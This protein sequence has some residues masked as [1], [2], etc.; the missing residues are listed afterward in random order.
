MGKCFFSKVEA[1]VETLSKR[2][3]ICVST[4]EIG[5]YWITSQAQL[6]YRDS[7]A[8]SRRE[9]MLCL[10]EIVK[11]NRQGLIPF[12]TLTQNE[13]V[14]ISENPRVVLR[15]IDSIKNKEVEHQNKDIRILRLLAEKLKGEVNPF[16][17][18]HL[19]LADRYLIGIFE[20]SEFV[21]WISHLVGKGLIS[22]NDEASALHDEASLSDELASCITE[23]DSIKLTADGWDTIFKLNANDVSTNV[24]VAMAFTDRT[25]NSLSPNVRDTIKSCLEKNGWTPIIVDEVEHNDGIMDKVLASINDA[26]FIVAELTHQ[27]SGVYYEAGYA[28]GRGLQVIHIVNKED[29]SNCHFDVKHLNLIIWQ[30]PQELSQKLENRIK[31]SIGKAPQ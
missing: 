7:H 17:F 27:K 1:H 15:T 2:D 30:D 22:L 29:F 8:L 31:A 6:S 10:Q 19:N 13:E 26:R 14:E 9:N 5:D 3:G 25:G 4:S 12:W 20:K 23:T 21:D 28:K 24:F 18:T 11:L 16:S